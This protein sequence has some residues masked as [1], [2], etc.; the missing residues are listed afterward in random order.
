MIA[1]TEVAIVGAGAAGIAAATTLRGRGIGCTVI[2]AAGRIGGRAWTTSG[3]ETADHWFDHGATWLHQ[4]ER[5]PLTALAHASG[6]GVID[7]D[8]HRA[9][10]LQIGARLATPAEQDGLHAARAR[11][12][13]TIRPRAA[14]DPD[15]AFAAAMDAMRDDPWAATLELWE[16][17]QIAAAD[18]ATF[19][20]R[21]WLINDLD[22]GNLIVE[23]GIGAF[24]ARL[25]ERAGPV[26]LNTPATAIEWSDGIRIATPRGTL[27][28]R[29]AIITVSTGVLPTLPFAP[30]LPVSHQE[31]IAG[32]PMG[33]LT[34]LAFPALGKDRLGLPDTMSIR[35]QAVAG[36]PTMGLFAWP[37]GAPYVQS[38]IGGPTAWALARQGRAATADFARGQIA[39]MLGAE[40]LKALGPALVTNWAAD[41]WHR[42]SYAFAL[43]GHAGARGVLGTP[44]AGGRLVFAGEATRTDGLA[45]TIGGAWL[46]GVEAA[47]GVMASLSA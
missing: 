16:A 36:E 9:W 15:I 7:S 37:Y 1:D 23:G 26:V 13:A 39:T 17:A 8:R 4:A 3:P 45:G 27:R 25:A 35:R 19:S 41:P 24:L 12:E 40:A 32:L 21:D 42:G 34:K 14:A 22:G 43:A 5:N 31:A 44:L 47:R 29:A 38:F 30:A 6:A 2:E 46:A 33:L 20:L 18:P 10:R 28:A 11:F